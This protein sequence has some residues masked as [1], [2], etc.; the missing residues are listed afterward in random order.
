METKKPKNIP[1]PKPGFFAGISVFSGLGAL[2]AK[3]CCILPFLLASSG[4]GS[5]WISRELTTLKPYFLTIAI[6]SLLIGW[7]LVIR[8]NREACHTDGPC[9]TSKAEWP[10]FTMLSLA[11]VLVGLSALWDFLQPVIFEYL[12]NST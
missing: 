4:I 6:L 3:S 10:T 2:A 11:T 1:A 5:A 7:F 12:K 9:A 8:R